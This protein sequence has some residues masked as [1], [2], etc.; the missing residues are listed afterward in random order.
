MLRNVPESNGVFPQ[1]KKVEDGLSFPEFKNCVAVKP[2]RF[3]RAQYS[4]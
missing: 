1:K 3:H 2:T 4:D